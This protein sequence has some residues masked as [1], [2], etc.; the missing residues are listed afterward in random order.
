MARVPVAAPAHKGALILELASTAI[1]ALRLLPIEALV[2]YRMPV[3]HDLAEDS[4]TL[5]M[6]AANT[7]KALAQGASYLEARYV[8]HAELDNIVHPYDFC[9][10][11]SAEFIQN[12]THVTV[13]K[14]RADFRDAVQH[15]LQH[16]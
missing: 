2:R 16:V 3:L 12:T 13:C 7:Q 4:R 14:P 6:L 5:T 1:G 9:D 10:D 15:L 11:P 8:V